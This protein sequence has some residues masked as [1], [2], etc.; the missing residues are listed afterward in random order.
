MKLSAYHHSVGGEKVGFPFDTNPIE[1]SLSDL[2]E[3]R[4]EMVSGSS[5]ESLW[6]ILVKEYHYL[7]HQRIFGRR[8]KY[9]A[10]VDRRPIAA[11]GWSTASIRLEARDCFIGWSEEQRK[12]YLKHVVNNNRFL[13]PNWI[14]VK[15]LA[16][17]LLARGIK[18]VTRDWYEKYG[19]RPF[20]LETFIDPGR[21]YGTSYKAVNWI[22]VGNSKGYGLGRAGYE[23]HGSLKEVYVYVVERDFRKII[24][25]R[26]RPFFW[27]C[28]ISQKKEK[29]DSMII[30]RADYNP[31]LIDWEGL[32]PEM[33]EKLAEELVE[34]HDE[35]RDAFCRVEQSILGQYYLQGLL[36]NVQR[37]NVEAIALQY[38]GAS[39]VRA[40][41]K[42]MTNYRWDDTVMLAKAQAML[43]GIIAEENG[44]ITLDGSD[45]PKKG[46]ESVGVRIC[47]T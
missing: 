22:Y 46:K 23:Y 44:M 42:F 41:Q 47:L 32:T 34:F 17:C 20:L 35:F 33:I 8:L 40:L 27:K 43:A 18:A 13:I 28:P 7:G 10:F 37:K 2:G 25:C 21:Y 4:L 39:R 38:L 14:R 30:Q 19:Q 29:A 6:N 15:N 31:D 12:K 11:L 5:L 24:N 26:Q 1:C 16:S 3:I 36:G 45:I 9:L